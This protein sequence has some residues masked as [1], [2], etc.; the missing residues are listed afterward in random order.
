MAQSERGGLD[1]GRAKPAD[2]SAR[3]RAR[4]RA[5]YLKKPRRPFSP[6]ESLEQKFKKLLL[7]CAQWTNLGGVIFTFLKIQ[8]FL[9]MFSGLGEDWGALTTAS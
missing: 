1:F 3:A 8:D 9:K 5:R 2:P 7:M 4:A 6:T